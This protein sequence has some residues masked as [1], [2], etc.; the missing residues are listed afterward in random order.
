[1]VPRLLRLPPGVLATPARR[2]AASI[3]IP[4]RPLNSWERQAGRGRCLAPVPQDI[5]AVGHST[6]FCCC[7]CFTLG[8]LLRGAL[9][10]HLRA[11]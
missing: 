2:H 3:S 10:E 6:A 8:A 5:L 1:M 7:C 11:A 4:R 9:P